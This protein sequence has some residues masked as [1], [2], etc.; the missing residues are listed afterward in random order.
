MS[1]KIEFLQRLDLGIQGEHN[2]TVIRI[3]CNSWLQQFPNG[4]ISLYHK[5]KGDEEPG[6]TGA[7]FDSKTGILSWSVTDT[8]TYYAGEGMATIQLMDA[9]IV[10]KKKKAL[11][12]VRPAVV[13]DV[14]DVLS[15]NWQAYI[16]EIERMKNLL[17]NSS[18]AW[19]V[20]TRGGT[21]VDSEDE[22]Y[23]N[24]SKY[25]H[26]TM[27]EVAQGWIDSIWE[28]AREAGE[29]IPQ[30]AS[31]WASVASVT[32]RLANFG[33]MTPDTEG[34]YWYTLTLE[35]EPEEEEP[36]EEEDA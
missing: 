20:G 32:H 3:D 15:S 2:A 29:L 18:E 30:D 23:H 16:N 13:N 6:V 1:L 27:A 24:N 7:S 10:K 31:F 26:D 21:P 33:Y 17:T 14:G 36:E 11:T 19:A 8:D 5:R 28:A 12:L 34:S 4:T 22:T 9:G 25:Y 35:E